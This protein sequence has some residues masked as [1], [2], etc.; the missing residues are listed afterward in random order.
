MQTSHFQPRLC[1]DITIRS[2]LATCGEEDC[3]IAGFSEQRYHSQSARIQVASI[4]NCY[5]N[6]YVPHSIVAKFFSALGRQSNQDGCMMKFNLCS[7]IVLTIACTLRRPFAL[8][9]EDKPPQPANAIDRSRNNQIIHSRNY[10]STIVFWSSPV[11]HYLF[12]TSLFRDSLVTRFLI[13]F[14]P[15]ACMKTISETALRLLVYHNLTGL[16][17]GLRGGD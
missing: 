1:L 16:T 7:R 15:S 4:P 14:H 9:G 5:T 13:R 17:A 11:A 6:I 2:S 8:S 3:G 10:T 12:V